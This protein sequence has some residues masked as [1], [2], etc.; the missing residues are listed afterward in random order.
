MKV[1]NPV[2][3]LDAQQPFTRAVEDCAEGTRR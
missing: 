3:A 2:L 1:M